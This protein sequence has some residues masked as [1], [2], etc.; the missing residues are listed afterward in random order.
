MVWVENASPAVD[1]Q[2]QYQ[3]I[4][5]IC[6][7]LSVLSITVVMTR[8]WIRLKARGLAADD[9]M[10]LLS[11]VFALIYSILC[12]VRKSHLLKYN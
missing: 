10:A 12:I 1:A 5:I 2:S 6:V 7:I 11:M 9:Y 4:I 3:T 8:A